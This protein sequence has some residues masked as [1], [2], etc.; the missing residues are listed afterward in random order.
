MGSSPSAR[1][2]KM[3]NIKLRPTEILALY[4]LLSQSNSPSLEELQDVYADLRFYMTTRLDE[5]W[6]KVLKQEEQRI[7]ALEDEAKSAT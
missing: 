4:V 1:S 3:M 2:G 6:H 5:N 7:A